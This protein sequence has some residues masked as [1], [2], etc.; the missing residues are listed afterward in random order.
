MYSHVSKLLSHFFPHYQIKIYQ[1]SGANNRAK[2]WS[3]LS[4]LK[5]SKTCSVSGYTHPYVFMLESA[6]HSQSTTWTLYV[7]N[8]AP[9]MLT[10]IYSCYCKIVSLH[11]CKRKR[12][13]N[14]VLS[15]YSQLCIK[16]CKHYCA[17]G[18]Q[19]LQRNF[20]LWILNIPFPYKYISTN[21]KVLSS[22][23]SVKTFNINKLHVK[24]VCN[25]Y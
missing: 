1:L 14:D 6:E 15:S 3:C 18:T 24:N 20:A 4:G 5:T 23:F 2:L 13:K 25:C 9:Y 11:N 16:Y 12:N 22:F 17:F 10:H 19:I 7:T 21:S 8:E